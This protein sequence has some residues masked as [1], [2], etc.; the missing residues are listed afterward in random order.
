MHGIQQTRGDVLGRLIIKPVTL[1]PA[2]IHNLEPNSHLQPFPSRGTTKAT[3][4]C[5]HG[6]KRLNLNLVMK[7]SARR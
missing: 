7:L 4:A 3:A 1:P 2:Q 6:C 5:I